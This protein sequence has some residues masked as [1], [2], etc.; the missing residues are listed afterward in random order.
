[1]LVFCSGVHSTL[2]YICSNYWPVKGWKTIKQLSKRCFICKY[3]Q[4]KSLLRPETPLL[5]EFCV[6]CYYSF[7]FVGVDFAGSIYYKS[8]YKVYKAQVFLSTCDVTPA[9][10]IELTKDLG[11]GSLVLGLR[12]FLAKPAKAELIINENF[13]TFQ[14]EHVKNFL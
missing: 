6:K 8:Q 3:V 14:S 4:G 10:N 7:K 13:K 1:M 12:R 2:S 9:F 5:P 11:N